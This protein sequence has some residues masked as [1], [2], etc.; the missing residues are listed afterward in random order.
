MGR[1]KCPQCEAAL[2]AEDFPVNGTIGVCPGC[3]RS[4]VREGKAA[5]LATGADLEALPAADVHAL[6][7]ARPTAWRQATQARLNQI[8][9]NKH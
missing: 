2:T 7:R 3:A 4:L 5:R 8:L 1:L 6:R 9:A